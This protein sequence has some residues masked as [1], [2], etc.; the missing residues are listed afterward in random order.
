L[1]CKNP[2]FK[3][4]SKSDSKQSEIA[5]DIK[6]KGIQYPI[7]RKCWIAIADSEDYEWEQEQPQIVVE[8]KESDLDA[9]LPELKLLRIT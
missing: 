1:P 8:Q 9:D 3:C 6:I 5:L 4:T 2:F 7:C